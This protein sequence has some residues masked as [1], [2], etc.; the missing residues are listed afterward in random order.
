[1]LYYIRNP[2]LY[3]ICPF[4]RIVVVGDDNDDNNNNNNNN[5]NIE[6]THSYP[7]H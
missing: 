4:S 6:T 5:N 1:V 7:V 2:S 3:G